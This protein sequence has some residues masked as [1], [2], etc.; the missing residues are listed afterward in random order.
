MSGS[1]T[2]PISLCA[3]ACFSRGRFRDQRG[4]ALAEMGIII[5][6]LV[7][8]SMGVME[9][10]RAWMVGNMI[11]HAAR[12]GARAA[13]LQPSSNRDASGFIIDTSGIQTLVND[14]ISDVGVTGLTVAVTY[15]DTAGTPM[16]RVTVSG[17]V[18]YFTGLFGTSFSVNRSITFRDEGR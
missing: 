11:T 14:E 12:D 3:G 8:L 18:D 4:Q 10:G 9:F 5:I 2:A 15:P 6:L 17:D 13:A 16:V 7:T 1:R